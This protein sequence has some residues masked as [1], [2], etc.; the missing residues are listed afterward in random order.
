MLVQFES[1]RLELKRSKTSTLG[2]PEDLAGAV[3]LY[4]DRASYRVTDVS[5]VLARDCVLYLYMQRM[6]SKPAL[7]GSQSLL[8]AING[9][10]ESGAQQAILNFVTAE[11]SQ[12]GTLPMEREH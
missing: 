7:G 9:I 12:W 1:H 8:E 11:G 5:S 6:Y 3:L 2:L 10:S 4:D